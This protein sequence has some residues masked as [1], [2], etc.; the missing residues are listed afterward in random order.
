M[1][2]SSDWN[3]D[4]F[5][6]SVN[7]NSSNT[8]RE[9]GNTSTIVSN[10]NATLDKDAFLKLLLIELQHQDPTDPMDS[11]KMLTQTS[12]LSALEMQQ[13]TNT[14]MQKMVETMQK[15]SDSFTT[16]MS[17]SALAAIGKM[18]TV[19]NNTI[20]LTGSDELIAL[21]MYL[22]EDSDENGV[23]LEI[24]DSNNKLV[25]SE[26]SDAKSISKGLFTMEWPGRNNDG[27]YAGDGEYS[28]KMVYNNKNGEK[29][30]ANYGTY[31]I[32]GVVFEN[33]VAYAKMAG[34]QVPF[35]AIKEITEYKSSSSSFPSGSVSNGDLNAGDSESA[36][37]ENKTEDESKEEKA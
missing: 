14:T 12:Q 32:E 9:S 3:L 6:A 34:Q 21:K 7:P 16:S 31:P 11:D 2:I 4:N 24:Y 17:T 1:M 27:V 19:T 28:V 26:K 8:L 20:K 30:T 13:N 37:D 25:F 23:T 36:Q 15:L 18:A 29:I 10:P 22:P 5:N 33:G 35:D